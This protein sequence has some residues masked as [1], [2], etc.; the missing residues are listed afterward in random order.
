[1]AFT[2]TGNRYAVNGISTGQESSS[3]ADYKGMTVEPQYADPSANDSTGYMDVDVDDTTGY[4]DVN[5]DVDED[6]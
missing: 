5:A 4:M 2:T 6:Y 3:D 1:L